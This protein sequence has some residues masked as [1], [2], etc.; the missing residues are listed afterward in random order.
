M[1]PFTLGQRVNTV[2]PSK[3]RGKFTTLRFVNDSL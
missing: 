2:K 1:S 3:V